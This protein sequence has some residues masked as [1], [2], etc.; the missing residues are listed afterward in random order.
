MT[1]YTK[2]EHGHY[3]IHGKK[4]EMLV[5]SRAQVMHGTAYKTTGGLTQDKLMRNKSGRFVSKK[6]SVDSKKNNRLL[7]HGY[8]SQKGKFGYVKLGS[9]TRKHRRS[10]KHH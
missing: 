8:G 10:R 7:E 4:F 3:H 2:D 9:K 1:R 5:G 6:K